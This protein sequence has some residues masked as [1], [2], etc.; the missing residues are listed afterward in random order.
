MFL[1]TNTRSDIRRKNITEKS[2]QISVSTL[3]D[4]RIESLDETKTVIS[5][6]TPV[7]PY[8][9]FS[10]F[11]NKTVGAH[12]YLLWKDI[13]VVRHLEKSGFTIKLKS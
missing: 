6:Q 3:Q 9:Q 8:S 13:K 12:A 4:V 10:Y 2:P 7:T 1:V 11:V 5:S